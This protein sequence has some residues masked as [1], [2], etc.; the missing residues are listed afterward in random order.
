MSLTFPDGAHCAALDD[1]SVTVA[2]A[3]AVDHPIYGQAVEVSGGG[4]VRDP[5]D[6][7]HENRAV[8]Y[9]DTWSSTARL[10]DE[11]SRAQ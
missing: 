9:D 11:E 8:V 6:D 5:N 1:G 10:P 4:I 3:T 2:L 7:A